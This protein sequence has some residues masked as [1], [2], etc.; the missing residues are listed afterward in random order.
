MLGFIHQLLKSS[1]ENAALHPDTNVNNY[2]RQLNVILRGIAEVQ[3]GIDQ[4]L[5][6]VTLTIDNH[7]FE[8]HLLCP[9]ICVITDTPAANIVCGHY[10]STSSEIARPHRTCDCTH[11]QLDNADRVCVFVHA[12]ELFELMTT[13]TPAELKLQSVKPVVNHAFAKLDVGDLTRNIFGATLTDIMHAIRQGTLRR[14][15]HLLFG[16]LTAKGKQTL[17]AYSRTFHR[18]HRQS[19]RNNFPRASFVDGITTMSQISAEEQAGIVF[20]LCCMLQQHD[21]WELFDESLKRQQ[22]LVEEVL[23]LLECLLCFDAWTRQATFWAADDVMA[24]RRAEDAISTLI[25]MIVL[26]LPREKGHGWKVPTLHSLKHLVREI[27]GNGAPSNYM[28]E[29]PE[30]NH[31][32]FAKRPGRASRKDNKTFERQAATRISDSMIIARAHSLYFPNDDDTTS[33]L[34]TEDDVDYGGGTKYTIHVSVNE[35]PPTVEWN[36]TTGAEFLELPLGLPAFIMQHYQRTT[37]LVVQTEYTGNQCGTLRC[38]PGY[39]EGAP[40]YDWIEVAGHGGRADVVPFKV[41]A[42]V[43]L[44]D[45]GTEVTRYELVGVPGTTRTERD[46]VLFTEWHIDLNFS[47]IRADTIVRRSFAVKVS[48][49]VVA[50]AFPQNE[51]AYHFAH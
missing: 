5:T 45:P 7:T 4:R 23:E 47:V 20:I 33:T 40:W 24:A 29:V 8:C 46:S 31:I 27:K 18:Q 50:I 28:A 34:D 21:V 6:N 41:L 51:W 3:H 43:P 22:L 49:K 44:R 35:L 1:A 9:I 39:R 12:A 15:N 19:E 16:C 10:N 48:P 26:R 13:G 11:D 42:V 37:P 30:H 38:H 36:T 17:D 32:R 14:S 2:H 25:E